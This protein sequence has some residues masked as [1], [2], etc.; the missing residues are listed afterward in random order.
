[1]PPE[2][3]DTGRNQWSVHGRGTP[4]GYLLNTQLF[5]TH[6]PEENRAHVLHI[7][8]VIKVGYHKYN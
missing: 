3:A 6:R 2:N 8:P 7:T 4:I 1:M 5:E